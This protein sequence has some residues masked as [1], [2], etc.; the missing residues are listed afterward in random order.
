M[1]DP[2]DEINTSCPVLSG[3]RP[4]RMYCQRLP[5]IVTWSNTQG[6]VQ[7][8][9]V[10][11]I[12]ITLFQRVKSPLQFHFNGPIQILMPHLNISMCPKRGSLDQ[13]F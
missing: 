5:V 3:M 6:Q 12:G 7:V 2:L 1:R 8:K 10:A 4:V 9:G 11:E 13:C